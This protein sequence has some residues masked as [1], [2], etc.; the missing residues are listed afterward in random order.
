M[1]DVKNSIHIVFLRLSTR[2]REKRGREPFTRHYVIVKIVLI[3]LE[4]YS[5]IAFFSGRR[6]R[7]GCGQDFCLLP[8]AKHS[9]SVL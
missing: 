5:R 4:A 7:T 2:K 9:H 6:A 1:S 8:D 3:V